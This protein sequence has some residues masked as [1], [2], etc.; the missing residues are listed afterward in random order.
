MY[1]YPM[2]NTKLCPYVTNYQFTPT[3]PIGRGVRK[4]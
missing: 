1:K 3:N 4:S 2:Y